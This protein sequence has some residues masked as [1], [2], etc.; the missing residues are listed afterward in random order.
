M[1][2]YAGE[3]ATYQAT[4]Q[5]FF[6]ILITGTAQQFWVNTTGQKRMTIKMYYVR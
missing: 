3:S 1:F 6:E 5:E 4:Y 2:S